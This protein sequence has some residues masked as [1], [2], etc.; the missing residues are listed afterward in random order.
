DPP[1]SPCRSWPPPQTSSRPGTACCCW[2]YRPRRSMG[3]TMRELQDDFVPSGFFALRTPL[4]PFDELL[5]WSAGLEAAA[6]CTETSEG[7]ENSEVIE[8][9]WNADCARL[10]QRL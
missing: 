7:L 9:A 1:A 4:L 10:R 3:A 5:A 8:A 6:A 2:R